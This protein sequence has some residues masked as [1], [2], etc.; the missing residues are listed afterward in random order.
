MATFSGRPRSH[1][2]DR[3]LAVGGECRD[4]HVIEPRELRVVDVRVGR[5]DCGRVLSPTTKV[6]QLSSK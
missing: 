1:D 4:Q 6:P 5:A 2:L 3:K